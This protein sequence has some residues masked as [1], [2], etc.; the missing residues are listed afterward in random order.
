MAGPPPDYFARVRG[1]ANVPALQNCRVVIVGVG[2]VGSRIADLLARSGVG[3]FRFI[4]H[5][6]L[7]V[8]NLF[9]HVLP[10][11]YLDWNKAAGLA[12]WLGRQVPGLHVDPVERRI[13][14]SVPA[15]LL[16]RWLSDADLIVAA[17]DDRE[18]QRRI[19]RQ[20]LALGVP[21]L[22]PGQYVEGGGEVFVQTDNRRPCFGC[23]DYF[24]GR[25]EPLRGVGGL[26]FAELPVIDTTLRLCVGMLDPD[27]QYR[28]ML[29]GEDGERYQAFRIDRSGTR[30]S[31]PQERRRDCPSC[32]GDPL[33]Q[34]HQHPPDPRRRRMWPIPSSQPLLPVWIALGAIIVVVTALVIGAVSGNSPSPSLELSRPSVPESVA[35]ASGGP[36]ASTPTPAAKY[37]PESGTSVATAKTIQPGEEEEGDS[38]TVAYGDGSCGPETGQFWKMSLHEGEEVKIVWGGPERHA[39]GLDVWPPGVSEIHGSGEGRVTYQSTSG[40]DNEAH[41]EA[42]TTGSYTIV[43]DESCGN[44]GPFHFTLTTQPG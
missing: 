23:W 40:E 21:A 38:G 9:R 16:E 7:Q 24:R 12:D 14:D 26:P 8:E 31:A 29:V 5:D 10:A 22:F 42:S 13:D 30:D 4:D 39:M 35:T 15:E 32:G 37:P 19:G 2:T 6:P 17:T 33:G 34:A 11:I 44:P 25:R 3:F 28:N 1:S 43:I 27:S 41:F 20:A 18:A 36:T